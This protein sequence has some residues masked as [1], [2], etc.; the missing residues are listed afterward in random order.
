MA[1]RAASVCD[2]AFREDKT[3]FGLHWPELVFVV[4][5]G[6]LFFGPKR[7]PEIGSSVGKTIKEFQ[8][9]MKEVIE[10]HN[11]AAVT[12]PPAPAQQIPAAPVATVTPATAEPPV[13]EPPVA[14][15]EHAND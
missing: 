15:V 9:S 3:M 11:S 12:P 14:A 13:A 2:A 1:E 5:I 6:L 10:P 4:I 7:L 8:K